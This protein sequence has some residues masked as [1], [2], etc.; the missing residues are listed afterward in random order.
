MRLEVLNMKDG[1]SQKVDNE[2]LLGHTNTVISPWV[3]TGRD[4]ETLH[5]EHGNNSAGI[6]R[7]STS[8][9]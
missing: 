9:P 8:M 2:P 3:A 4:L 1:M 7:A 6:F 5:R